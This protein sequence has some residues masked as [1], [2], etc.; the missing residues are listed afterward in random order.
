[1]KPMLKT[2]VKPDSM[3]NVGEDW[4]ALDKA[5]KESVVELANLTK[6]VK[7][8]GGNAGKS[9]A[10][11]ETI[12]KISKAFA[13]GKELA[14]LVNSPL[15]VRAL[16]GVISELGA[17]APLNKK[18]FDHVGTVRERPSVILLEDLRQ[19]YL[20]HHDQ[21]FDRKA[22]EFWLVS[23]LMKRNQLKQFDTEIFSAE[24]PKWLANECIQQEQEFGNFVSRLSLD[25]Y[26]SG[27]F[28][29]V[30]QQIYFVERLKTI[31][32][33]KP[34]HLLEEIQKQAVYNA[35]YDEE[36]L[37][38]HEI[39]KTLI[40]RAPSN[41]VHES[42][43]NVV[44]QIAGD[45]RVDKA[46]PRY[47]KW[48]LHLDQTL[49]QKVIGWLSGLD[50]KL[51]LEALEDYSKYSGNDEL[52]R[53]YPARR[54]FLQGLLDR[55]LVTRTRL[56]LT[57]RFK[58]YLKRNYNDEHLPELYDV[59]TNDKSIIHVQLGK[60]HL[61]EGSHSAKLWIYKGLTE[62][63]VVFDY[64]K[65]RV[66]YNDLTSELSHKMY[67]DKGQHLLVDSITHHP[68]LTWQKKAIEAMKTAG[69]TVRPEDV[70]TKGDY[71]DY[72]RKFGVV[73]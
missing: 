51:F 31:P 40:S 44:M 65:R 13:E 11:K 55:K 7:G 37:L 66:S 10:L 36:G 60:T 64:K 6:E 73:L 1:M 61:I 5:V 34:D 3:N 4:T 39:L 48:W 17:K 52:I 9:D 63:A 57:P 26:Q 27:R 70:L 2:L 67:D 21:L 25:K 32:V 24:G 53:M 58:N 33:N 54:Q 59:S 56:Y 16:G 72:K 50:L 28:I 8:I 38:G 14:T 30:A 15:D 68:T 69:V 19:H 62:K 12:Q 47:Q 41:D 45:P 18:L 20:T 43:R 22:L 23:S 71:Y 46:H 35:P 49:I 42:W 29:T